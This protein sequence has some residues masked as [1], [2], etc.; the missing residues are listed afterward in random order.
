MLTYK[1]PQFILVALF[2]TTAQAGF[3]TID[4]SAVQNARMQNFAP[5][6]A[7]LFPSGSVVL[8]GTPFAIPASGNN[9]WHSADTFTTTTGEKSVDIMVNAFGVIKVETLMNTF[10]GETALGTLASIEFFG[11]SGAIH[12]VNLDG[13]DMIRDYIDNGGV[14]ANTI[15]GTTAQNVFSNP[16]TVPFFSSEIRLD[17]QTFLL[18]SDFSN[19]T[20]TSIRLNDFGADGVQRLFLAGVTVTAVPEPSSGISALLGLAVAVGMKRRFRR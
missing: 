7:H 12:T 4:F 15:N 16:F 5:P 11:S 10:W 8:G 20:L 3:I 9:V 13:G 17:K 1:I 2:C 6:N 18:P 14:F 19:Q